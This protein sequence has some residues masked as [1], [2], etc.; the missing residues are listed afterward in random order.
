MQLE[1]MAEKI[2]VTEGGKKLTISRQRAIIKRLGLKAMNGETAAARAL[3]G[4]MVS[5]EQNDSQD[6]QPVNKVGGSRRID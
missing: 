2:T 1:E 6:Q 4:L 5:R 3:L